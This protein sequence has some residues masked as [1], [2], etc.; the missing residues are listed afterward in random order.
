MAS[1]K[2]SEEVAKTF[3]TISSEAL[4]EISSFEEAVA[5]AQSV[6]GTE[7]VVAASDVLGDGFKLLGN[8]DALIDVPFFAVT[9]NFTMGDHG[10]FVAVKVITKDGQK[11]IVTDGSKGI[12]EMLANYSKSSGRYGGLFVNK[13]LRRS[14]YTYED[15]DGT[16]KAARTYYLDV[17]A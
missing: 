6:Y 13:G 16:E 4:A 7:A 10:E 15:E 1:R 8:K 14:D 5:L 9:W 17:S 2:T 3:P 11:L 12:Y